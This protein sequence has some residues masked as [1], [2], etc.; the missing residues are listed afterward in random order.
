MALVENE[1]CG[2]FLR[3]LR[4]QMA[5]TGT[6][7]AIL[8]IAWLVCVAVLMVNGWRQAEFD[9]YDHGRRFAEASDRD[10]RASR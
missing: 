7:L 1:V 4:G 5:M 10:R 3:R 2:L 9:E 6:V 8:G